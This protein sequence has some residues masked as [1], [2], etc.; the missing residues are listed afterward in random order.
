MRYRRRVMPLPLMLYAMPVIVI[1][2]F[3]AT[4]LLL[5]T[6]PICCCAMLFTLLRAMKIRYDH[7]STLFCRYDAILLPRDDA[8]PRHAAM[9]AAMPRSD[10]RAARQMFIARCRV[11]AITRRAEGMPPFILMQRR[12]PPGARITRVSASMRTYAT[13]GA[14]STMERATAREHVARYVQNT[15]YSH[16]HVPRCA[17]RRAVMRGFTL[18]LRLPLSLSSLHCCRLR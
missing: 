18:T 7:S 15:K 16:S 12:V 13:H 17:M 8:A 11:A 10:A 4:P 3:S 6:P 9:P 2:R 14:R 1:T 5:M